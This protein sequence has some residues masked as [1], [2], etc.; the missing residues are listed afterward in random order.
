MDRLSDGTF[1]RWAEGLTG[2]EMAHAGE[3]IRL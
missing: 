3:E 1:R 2:Y